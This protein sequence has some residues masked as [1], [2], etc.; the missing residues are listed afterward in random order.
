MIACLRKVERVCEQAQGEGFGYLGID[1]DADDRARELA[2]QRPRF[3]RELMKAL[4]EVDDGGRPALFMTP[5]QVERIS[6]PNQVAPVSQ[7]DRGL[8]WAQARAAAILKVAKDHGFYAMSSQGKWADRIAAALSEAGMPGGKTNK[9]RGKNTTELKG[10]SVET[11]LSACEAHKHSHADRYDR[12]V[13][14]IQTDSFLAVDPHERARILLDEINKLGDM[15]ALRYG[16]RLGRPT[17]AEN[18]KDFAHFYGMATGRELS[19]EALGN[20]GVEFP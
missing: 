18:R 9:R 3:Y 8:K 14:Q 10:N 7:R 4:W 12:F 2:R 13:K 6:Q 17:D 15:V 5:R 19:D 1:V 11:W 16:H 20:L